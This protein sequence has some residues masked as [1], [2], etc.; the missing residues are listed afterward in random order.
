MSTTPVR[1]V[2]LR[3]RNLRG[4]LAAALLPAPTAARADQVEMLTPG[5]DDEVDAER[6][7]GPN[8]WREAVR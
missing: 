6:P 5:V 4:T 2:R 1:R 3:R 8:P 7:F